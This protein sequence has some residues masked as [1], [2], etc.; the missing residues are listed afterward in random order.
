MNKHLEKLRK[1]IEVNVIGCRLTQEEID[2]LIEPLL[3]R[4]AGPTIDLDL[5]DLQGPYEFLEVKEA[6]DGKN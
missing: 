1:K 4:K 2:Y 5:S 3:K 6:E